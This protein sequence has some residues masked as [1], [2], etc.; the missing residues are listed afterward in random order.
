M[1]K[2]T[3]L[4]AAL[5]AF[6]PLPLRA[7]T[8]PSIIAAENFYGDIA[9]QIAGTEVQVTSIMSNPD[10][11][12]HLLEAD[13][14]TAR[15]LSA[16]RIVIYNGVDYDPWVAK[17]LSASKAAHRH[18]IVV[19]DLLHHKAGVNPHLWYDPAAVPT[20]ART[21]AATLDAADPVNR[22]AYD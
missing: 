20:V 1:Q 13:P 15:N 6:A 10:E 4:M 2:I 7:A 3:R 17:L 21:P 18:V 5:V 14:A 8:P 16:A 19:G 22:T 12:P 9:R 11:D